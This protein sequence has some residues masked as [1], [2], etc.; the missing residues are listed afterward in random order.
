MLSRDIF[1]YIDGD[2]CIWEREPL[3]KLALEHE[4]MAYKHKGFW[5]PI[6]TLREKIQIEKMWQDGNAPWKQW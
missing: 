3:E 4:L 5:Q 1:N 6:D 2:D